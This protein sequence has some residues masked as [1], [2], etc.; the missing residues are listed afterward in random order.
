MLIL[1]ITTY[2]HLL[3]ITKQAMMLSFEMVLELFIYSVSRSTILSF[4]S[5]ISELQILS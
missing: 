1:F 5:L 2:L 3:H 4:S